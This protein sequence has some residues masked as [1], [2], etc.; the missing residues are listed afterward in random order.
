[1]IRRKY[2]PQ[3]KPARAITVYSPVLTFSAGVH[4]W[5]KLK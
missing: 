2:E 1:M 5:H 3:T 4:L